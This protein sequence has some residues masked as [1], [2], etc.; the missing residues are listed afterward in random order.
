[1]PKVEAGPRPTLASCEYDEEKFEAELDAWKSRQQ[2][3]QQEQSQSQSVAEQAREEYAQDEQ[4]YVQKRAALPFK[5]ADEVEATALAVL[6]PVQEAAIK[7]AA[8]DAALV[9]QALGRHPAKLAE[10]SKIQNPVKLAYAVGKLELSLKVKAM[11][12]RQ[13]TDPEEIQTGSAGMSIQRGDKHEEKLE[14]EAEKSG[15]YSALVAY[16]HQRKS[17]AR[18]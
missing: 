7:M 2:V 15:D 5:D 9:L 17:Q 11:P 3:E 18:K 6:N 10:L 16:R 13:V 8:N 14:K 4:R 12:R 1:M